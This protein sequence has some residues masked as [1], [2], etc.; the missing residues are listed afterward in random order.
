MS[1]TLRDLRATMESANAGAPHPGDRLEL[2]RRRV[3]RSGRLRIAAGTVATALLLGL[4]FAV[5]PGPGPAAP[6]A[7]SPDTTFPRRLT[8]LDLVTAV[9]YDRLRTTVDLTF[10]PTGPTTLISMTCTQ[11]LMV[12]VVPPGPEQPTVECGGP[13]PGASPST[14]LP[15]GRGV[16]LTLKMVAVPWGR[17]R[18]SGSTDSRKVTG[19]GWSVGIYS[20]TC[21]PGACDRP[22]SDPDTELAGRTQ[23]GRGLGTADGRKQS[24]SFT[25][26]K[27]TVKLRLVCVE[28]AAWAVL[29]QNGVRAEPIPCEAA[30]AKGAFRVLT[31]EPGKRLDLQIVVFPAST[32]PVEDPS[33]ADITRLMKRSESFG[34]WTLTLHEPG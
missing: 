28:G 11:P 32:N 24:F 26:G 21:A 33:E 14:Y 18:Q 12:Y 2:I 34:G 31:V 3:R 4:A 30:E 27:P 10:T 16:P 5:V 6:T 23:I 13:V 9:R 1:P 15:I 7:G 19:D 20:G 8:G 17:P 22:A 29:W 25:P